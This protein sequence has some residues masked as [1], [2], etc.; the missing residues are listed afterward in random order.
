MENS[1][2]WKLIICHLPKPETFEII[3]LLDAEI[4]AVNMTPKIMT[5][6]IEQISRPHGI[7]SS[8]LLHCYL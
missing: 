1:T 5:G 8:G 6:P 7:F 4:I 3:Y 2:N